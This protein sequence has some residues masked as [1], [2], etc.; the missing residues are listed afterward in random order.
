MARSDAD[1]VLEISAENKKAMDAIKEVRDGMDEAGKHM[2][3]AAK[4]AD[5]QMSKSFTHAFNVE[6]IKN[7]AIQAGKWLVDFGKE[8][9]NAAS[10]LEE[11]QNVVDTT[12]GSGADAIQKWADSARTQFGLTE[13]QA[14][15]FTST[16]GSMMKSSGLAGDEIVKMST[17]LAG[18]AADMASFYNLDFDTAFQKIR[19]GISGE[20]EPL[21][22]LGIN[23]SVANLQ[24]FALTQGITKAF[25]KMTQGEQ[26]MLR[27]QYMMQATAD[28][29]G[30]FARTS[31]G[32]ANSVRLF[33]TNLESL[34]TNI[35][36]LLINPLTE[37]SGKLNNLIE[38]LT[39]PAKVTLFDEF[40]SINIETE[41]KL[42]EIEK[43]YEKATDLNNVLGQVIDRLALK[44]PKNEEGGEQT[45][46][47]T[48]LFEDEIG[49][50]LMLGSGTDEAAQKLAALG[51]STEEIERAQYSWLQVCKQLVNAIPSLSD[52]I[53]TNTGEVKVGRQEIQGYIDE[54]KRMKELDVQMTAL[55]KKRAAVVNDTTVQDRWS[56]WAV[57]EARYKRAVA[58]IRGREGYNNLTPE[59]I[60][61]EGIRGVSTRWRPLR[62]TALSNDYD[63]ETI[64]LEKELIESSR[65]LQAARA[66]LDKAESDR[67]KALEDLDA[68]E[69]RLTADQTQMTSAIEDATAA[70]T[71]MERAATGDE[72][73]LADIV[74]TVNDVLDALSALDA[75][76]QK[77]YDDTDKSVRQVVHGFDK[78]VTPATQTKEKIFDLNQQLSQLAANDKSRDPLEM[79]RKSMEATLPSAQNMTRGLQDQIRYMKEYQFFLEQ[80]KERG[81]ND[82]LIAQFSDG[83]MESYDYL[84]AILTASDDE[85]AKLNEAYLENK[86][87]REK[88]TAGL[89]DTKLER[90]E[91]YQDLVS[92]AETAVARLQELE[93][94]ATGA[95]LDTMIGIVNALSSQKTAVA[96]QVDE[97]IGIIGRLSSVNYGFSLTPG[98]AGSFIGG[99]HATPHANGLD[100]VPYD[101]Y[102]ASLHEGESILTA[103]EAKVWREF[104]QSGT[105]SRNSID[106]GRMASAIW[107][108]APQMGGGNV[109]LDGQT[110]G[111]VISANQA[112]AYRSLQRS[113]WSA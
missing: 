67:A 93:G 61:D 70:M 34:Q 40:N 39:T 47:E 63:R 37:A 108:T 51:Y 57:A 24:A 86:A 11:V 31:D 83:S 16:L 82:E 22:Q 56:D 9:I 62:E 58:A 60:T 88:F 94:V 112:N 4:K 80:A 54:W 48:K 75:Y 109:Y 53:D 81:L 1:V 65:A 12:F 19:S 38:K 113:G 50:L 18:L 44:R 3:D 42:A 28:A 15:R 30:D 27:Y 78:I 17:D 52:V 68:V 85:I 46:E 25:D 92:E 106:Y 107:D 110:V 90:D 6:R 59:Q 105:A 14:K 77:V 79:T 76:Q 43:V 55:E 26:V 36:K 64:A 71:Q 97:I 72:E 32:Y 73:A 41:S 66:D 7:W 84:R 87:E 99:L 69:Q 45:E 33:Q 111:R 104:K 100:Y 102:L 5:D 8:A 35:G 23:M 96:T 89:T 95:V 49:T 2:A 103:Q 91:A 101:S 20:T 10:D 29:Q 98:F 13:T 21:K 74:E